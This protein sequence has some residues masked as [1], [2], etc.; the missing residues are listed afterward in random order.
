MMNSI[1]TPAVVAGGLY[2]TEEVACYLKIKV[3]T[4]QVWRTTGRYP[5]L[6]WVKVGGAVR[7]RGQDV[8]NFVNGEHQDPQPYVPKS[9]RPKLVS[10]P[11]R[12]KQAAR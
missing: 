9:R 5:G 12:Y 11:R 4:L 3:D 1:E 8:L 6:K 7:Y 2:T 10:K